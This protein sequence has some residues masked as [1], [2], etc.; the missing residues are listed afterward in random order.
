MLYNNRDFSAFFLRQ[1]RVISKIEKKAKFWFVP[2]ISILAAN[3]NAI[4]S[5]QIVPDNTLPENSVVT[6]NANTSEITGGTTLGD[7]LFHS[8]EQFSVING[9][10]A[11]FNNESAL[12]NIIGRVTGSSISEIDG[13]IRTNGTANL[14]LINPNGII[15]G[16]NASLDIGGSFIGSTADSLQFADNTEFSAVN[17][18]T[19]ALLTVSIPVGLQ[20]GANAESISVAGSG[21]NLSIDL[22]TYT[23]DRT[24]RPVGLEVADNNTLALIGGDIDLRGG[25][26]TASGGTIELGS[27]GDGFVGLEIAESDISLNYDAIATFKNISLSKQASVE[28]SGDGGN[29]N[30]NGAIVSINDGSAILADTLGDAPGGG[31][32]ISATES[33]EIMGFAPERLF[34]S[35]VGADVDLGATGD[36]G[37][38]TLQTPYLFLA[39]GGQSTTGTFGL[40]NSGNTTVRAIDI[41]IIGGYFEPEADFLAPSGLYSQSDFGE[42]GNGGNLNIEADYMLLAGGGRLSTTSFGTG[43][44]GSIN[45]DVAE[46]ELVTGGAGFGASRIESD[47]EDVGNG[48]NI[49]ISTDRFFI[50][51]GAQVGAGTFWTGDAGNIAITANDLEI[52]GTSPSGVGAGIFTVVNP[53]ATGNGGQLNIDATNLL[54]ADGGQ[55]AVATVGE[56]NASVLNMNAQNI[57]LVGSGIS[58]ASGLFSSAI[59]GT[60]DGGNINLKSDRL[61]I[62]N[63]ATISASNF[64][65]RNPDTPPGT[66]S[67]G[68][69]NLEVNSLELDNIEP[70]EFSSINASAYAKDGGNINISTNSLTVNNGSQILADTKGEGDGGNIQVTASKLDLNG[71]GQISASSTATGQAGNIAIASPDVRLDAGKITAA[72]L[73]AGG[74]SINLITNTLFM[75]N[76]S[77]IDTSVADSTGGGGNIAIDNEEFI[78]GQNNSSIRAD[79]VKGEG[80]NI[81]INARGVFFDAS[82]T[83]TASS[84][85]GVDGIVDINTIESDQKIGTVQL[86]N[87]VERPN[88][89]IASSCPVSKDNTFLI[90]GKGGL[91][92]DP[93][94]YLRGQ[95][96]WQDLRLDLAKNDKVSLNQLPLADYATALI[97]AQ[98]WKLNQQGQI[99]LVA[100]RSNYVELALNSNYQCH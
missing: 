46:I 42:T 52:A 68:T 75:D 63:G 84:R 88:S 22:D 5:A 69:I 74:G 73:E 94:Q 27:V 37:N 82:S 92:E 76:G 16:N 1:S 91:P 99:E 66:G 77:A 85:F 19:A 45:V 61:S 7:N 25:N 44:A 8:F 14:F 4:A 58:A 98:N 30:L 78:I 28:T 26:L 97:E 95:A 54:V 57:E 35:R 86:P 29:V 70:E 15:F 64:S 49:D 48:G 71:R 32:N 50:G 53:G 24:T 60:G 41:E 34:T 59:L 89:V 56:G 9:Q 17:P 87:N 38:I 13:L 81:Q 23:I 83:I 80:G 31:I 12:E 33:I 62:S 72:S 6:P 21:N 43:N 96:T 100:S 67:A 51:F 65:S 55:I 2:F 36:G 79:A 93:G 90:S 39:D 47:T 10:T 11:F 20:Y 3:I 40:G 18:N